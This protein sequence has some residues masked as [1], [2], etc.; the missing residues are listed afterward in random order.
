MDSI[1]NTVKKMLGLQPDY[2]AFDVDVL[3]NINAAL[4]S[5]MQIGVG[6]EEGFVVTGS[7][8]TWSDFLEASQLTEL[9][10]L[11]NYVYLK[12]RTLFDPPTNSSVL[13]A[14]NKVILEYEWRMNIQVDKGGDEDDARLP[15]SLRSSGDEVG[16]S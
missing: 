5:L 9:G 2:N 1:L 14:M 7:D 4:M 3:V 16:S 12:V 10:A 13:E 15:D 8:E 6:P 11:Q